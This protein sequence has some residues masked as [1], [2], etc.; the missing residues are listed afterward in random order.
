M[1]YQ[2]KN[3]ICQKMVIGIPRCLC[4]ATVANC[5]TENCQRALEGDPEAQIT[6]DDW[7]RACVLQSPYCTTL[8]EQKE[9][10]SIIFDEDLIRQHNTKR[11][12]KNNKSNQ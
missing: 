10:C 11:R 9:A 6:I 4:G 2:K 1:S 12:Q 8:R 5:I 3:D 7:K